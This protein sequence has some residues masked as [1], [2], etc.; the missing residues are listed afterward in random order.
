MAASLCI[1]WS[2][3]SLCLSWL[4][5]CVHPDNGYLL[6]QFSFMKEFF[7]LSVN[8]MQQPL[9]IHP[10]WPNHTTFSAASAISH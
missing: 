3:G 2:L 5:V 1:S 9:G 7:R 4:Q 10:D 6:I 8:M